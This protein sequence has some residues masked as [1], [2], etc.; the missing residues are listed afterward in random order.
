MRARIDDSMWKAAHDQTIPES[1]LQDY[2]E[3]W[4]LLGGEDSFDAWIIWRRSGYIVLPFAGGWLDQPEWLREDFLTLDLV[5]QW[6]DIQVEKPSIDH[7][8]DPYE[9][10]VNGR[11]L[12]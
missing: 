4:G 11:P 3:D 8:T 7:I 6:H 5:R 12:T 9:S 2:L 10:Y 1:K